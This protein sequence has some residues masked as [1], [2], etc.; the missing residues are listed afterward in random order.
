MELTNKEIRRKSICSAQ[1]LLKMG[2]RKNDVLGFY[3]RNSDY[4]APVI[5][6]SLIIGAPVNPLDPSFKK[7]VT[8]ISYFFKGIFQKLVLFTDEIVHMFKYTKPSLVFSDPDN[9]ETLAAALT[10]LNRKIP[11]LVF[12]NYKN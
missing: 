8:F 7:C 3:T 6:G 2:I 9:V 12:G 5:F 10:E 1:N 4:L 11:I